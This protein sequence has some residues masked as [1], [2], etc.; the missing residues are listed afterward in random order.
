MMFIL[1]LCAFYQPENC[2][3]P[4]KIGGLPRGKS[5]SPIFRLWLLV[6]N[7]KVAGLDTG[8]ARKML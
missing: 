8:N 1:S 2:G 3:L 5:G 7:D 4:G 6:A